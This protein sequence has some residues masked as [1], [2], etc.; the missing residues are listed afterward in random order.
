M[1]QPL[2]FSV[3]VRPWDELPESV[4]GRLA[5][6][7]ADERLPPADAARIGLLEPAD[8]ARLSAWALASIPPGWPELPD[9][10]FAHEDVLSLRDRWDDPAGHAAVRAWLYGRGVPFGRT[11]YL[12]YDRDRVVRTTWKVVVRHWDAFAW[13][14]GYA[15]VAV[16]HTLRWA[17]CFHHEDVVVFGSRGERPA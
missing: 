10:R 12:L 5:L 3:A 4:R 7:G 2:P 17:C 16:D 8:A 11:V 14:V 1:E 9:A 15:M 6:G 13:P